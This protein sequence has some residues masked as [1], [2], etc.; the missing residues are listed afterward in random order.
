MQK[1]LAVTGIGPHSA[2]LLAATVLATLSTKGAEAANVDSNLLTTK[3]NAEDA[4]FANLTGRQVDPSATIDDVTI[5]IDAN[6][7]GLTK[8]TATIINGG[9]IETGDRAHV[10]DGNG[11]AAAPKVNDGGHSPVARFAKVAIDAFDSGLRAFAACEVPKADTNGAG[12]F[13][14][15]ISPVAV[16]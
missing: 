14:S 6:N 8:L 13:V 9:H 7:V 15:S 2:G 3:G 16:H 11:I 5:S 1:H 12:W 10:P 4:P